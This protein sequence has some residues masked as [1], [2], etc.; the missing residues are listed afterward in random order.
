MMRMF[1]KQLLVSSIILILTGCGINNAQI[2]LSEDKVY[3]CAQ[4]DN[5][6]LGVTVYDSDG[7][8]I[9]Q[10]SDACMK[11]IISSD[12]M[13]I[14]RM[15]GQ[16]PADSMLFIGL[17]INTSSGV[18]DVSTQSWAVEPT[19]GWFNFREQNEKLISFSIGENS[20]DA[21]CR[22]LD[23]Q[24]E[25]FEIKGKE[26]E[27]GHDADGKK[28]IYL[29]GELY[30]DE[31]LFAEKNKDLSV[32]MPDTGLEV[33]GV[34]AGKYMILEGEYS[35]ENSGEKKH[36][37]YLCDE[38]GRIQY[39][40]WNHYEI[41][42]AENQYKETDLNY[43]EFRGETSEIPSQ[44][45]NVHTGEEISIPSEFIIYAANGLFYFYTGN[46]FCIYDAES[47]AYGETFM[48]EDS[49]ANIFVFGL[50]TY[51]IQSVL[52]SKY[53]KLVIE[54]EELELSSNVEVLLVPSSDFP[55]VL[56]GELFGPY[57]RSYIIDHTGKLV[58]IGNG[59][60]WYAD[61]SYYLEIDGNDYAIKKMME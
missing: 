50:H 35:S 9:L 32:P 41:R 8:K 10:V 36:I 52:G 23:N 34:V 43:I 38:N 48:P 2:K 24:K 60:V 7:E 42:Y 1:M 54:G 3:L 45:L 12:G 40:D 31:K 25:V 46:N 21:E 37:E 19:E 22:P 30:L 18:W 57:W 58:M 27:N 55:I 59:N 28:G 53:S 44:F 26:L 4:N 13:V 29:K 56:E 61:N 49:I 16:I 6:A 33:T 39:P 11:K 20:Y 51:V 17:D 47:H 14:D 5:Y 15:M